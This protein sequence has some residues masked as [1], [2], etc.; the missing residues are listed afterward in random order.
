MTKSNENKKSICTTI[1]AD[2][3]SGQSAARAAPIWDPKHTYASCARMRQRHTAP[4]TKPKRKKDWKINRATGDGPKNHRARKKEKR[5]I[6]KSMSNG[7]APQIG[8][9]CT[10]VKDNAK[11]WRC[12][13]CR[14]AL[15]IFQFFFF[16]F[17]REAACLRNMP[18][19]D[20]YSL[21]FPFYVCL[22]SHITATPAASCSIK[23]SRLCL[24]CCTNELFAF[25]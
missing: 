18:V 8:K 13:F 7:T 15:L 20:G 23:R 11:G 6:S 4:L 5:E 17:A 21:P 3:S 25:V 12:P 22:R 9:T 1:R 19:Y 14:V 24:N 2:R 10:L 16:S